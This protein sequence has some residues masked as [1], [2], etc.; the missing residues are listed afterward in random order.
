VIITHTFSFVFFS[1]F[2]KVSGSRFSSKAELHQVLVGCAIVVIF[3]ILPG[4]GCPALVEHAGQNHVVAQTNAKASGRALGQ[5][6][7]VMLC[8]HNFLVLKIAMQKDATL[9]MRADQGGEL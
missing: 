3:A 4:E 2:L 5:I 8:F 9:F 6:N 1:F 7:K